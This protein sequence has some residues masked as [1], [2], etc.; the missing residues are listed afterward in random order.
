VAEVIR[1]SIVGNASDAVRALRQ[2]AKEAERAEARLTSVDRKRGRAAVEEKRARKALLTEMARTR[3]ETLA[4]AH[5]RVAAIAGVRWRSD[6]RAEALLKKAIA[7]EEHVNERAFTARIVA[8]KRHAAALDRNTARNERLALANRIRWG[9]QA[10]NAQKKAENAATAKAERHTAAIAKAALAKSEREAKARINLATRNRVA[11]GLNAIKARAKAESDAEKALAAARKKFAADNVRTAKALRIKAERLLAQQTRQAERLAAGAVTKAERA[12]AKAERLAANAVTRAERAA[13]AVTKRKEREQ[14]QRVDRFI[15]GFSRSNSSMGTFGKVSA[16]AV[17]VASLWGIA[18]LAAST[19]TI[20]LAGALAPLVGLMVALPAAIVGGVAVFA[21]LDL[22]LGGVDAALKAGIQG[23]VELLAKKMKLIPPPARAFVTSILALKKPMADLR[24]TVAGAFFT[25]LMGQIKP[26]A[27]IYL[28]LLKTG[29][30]AISGAVGGVVKNFAIAARGTAFVAGIRAVLADAADGIRAFGTAAAPAM[31]ALGQSLQTGAPLLR[32][33][34]AWLGR[35]TTSFANWILAAA[36]T[37]RLKAW[38]DGAVHTLG[39]FWKLGKNILGILGSI[40]SAGTGKSGAFLDNLVS[41][42]GRLD[43]FLNTAK[44]RTDLA[45]FFTKLER[46]SKLMWRALAIAVPIAAA[47]AAR[48]VNDILPAVERIARYLEQH[49]RTAKTLA[50]AV[51]ALWSSWKALGIVIA[52][53]GRLRWVPAVL[54]GIKAISLGLLVLRNRWIGVAVAEKLAEAANPVGATILL[55]VA[56]A[57]AAFALGALAAKY[58]VFPRIWQAWSDLVVGVANKIGSFFSGAMRRHL[59]LVM[60]RFAALPGQM[61]RAG[62]AAIQGFIDGIRLRFG[63]MRDAIRSIPSAVMGW[64]N[65]LF[66]N[67]SPSRAM[68]RIG[69]N[70]IAGLIVGIRS[71][72]PQ[73]RA[74]V[75]GIG[76]AVTGLTV[77]AS[78]APIRP[79]SVRAIPLNVH[80][81]VAPGGNLAEAGRQVVAAVDAYQRRHGRQVQVR[82]I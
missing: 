34:G 52:I 28:P 73:L 43:A 54:R 11:W 77:P 63:Q 15:K 8:E 20:Q 9:V 45:N 51:A 4:A 30:S 3:K 49:H 60:A 68:G 69:R 27:A 47:L 24:S 7:A 48:F 16:R 65:Q 6:P 67:R 72:M 75:S 37:G 74:T 12:A 70:A 81:H 29:L 71:G 36:R 78:T 22:A 61:M 18:A 19:P 2:T 10:I 46:T 23:N 58:R 56:L 66:E 59:D 14:Q 39:E 44:G 41:M 82:A 64:L 55:G 35:I 62:T 21:A 26:L 80:V 32:Q 5:R 25:P 40:F 76:T 50:L 38:L 57:A 42:T 79:E 13:A 33:F 31:D 17:A 53:V 1:I